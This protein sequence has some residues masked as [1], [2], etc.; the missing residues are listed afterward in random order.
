MAG[1]H[2]RSRSLNLAKGGFKSEE[3]RGFLHLQNKI[4][5][6]NHYPEQKI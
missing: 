4:D 6:P 2:A 1:I 3:T 5:I